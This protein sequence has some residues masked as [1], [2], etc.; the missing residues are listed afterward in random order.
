MGTCRTLKHSKIQL[1]VLFGP[2]YCDILQ[3]IRNFNYHANVSDNIDTESGKRMEDDGTFVTI[4]PNTIKAPNLKYNIFDKMLSNEM[5]SIKHHLFDK[6]STYASSVYIS[7]QDNVPTPTLE[8]KQKWPIEKLLL[9]S[10]IESIN[11]KSTE[12][13]DYD[14]KVVVFPPYSSITTTID[15]QFHSE[16]ENIDYTKHKIIEVRS[17]SNKPVLHTKVPLVLR[18]KQICSCLK[19]N[20]DTTCSKHCTASEGCSRTKKVCTHTDEYKTCQSECTRTA[21]NNIMSITLYPY[22]PSY[23]LGVSTDPP[24]IYYHPNVINELKLPKHKHRH[25]NKPYDYQ[26]EENEKDDKGENYYYEDTSK[27]YYSDPSVTEYKNKKCRKCK[28]KYN[29]NLL[30]TVDFNS[31]NLEVESKDRF[32]EEVVEDLKAYYSDAVIRDCYCSFS[33]FNLKIQYKF[34]MLF[35]GLIHVIM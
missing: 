26:L 31:G 18:Q 32:I 5:L 20:Q 25:S 21:F 30:Q 28:Y 19:T 24:N 33:A 4:I 15:N 2:Y 9:K 3:N 29:Q 1:V 12:E 6:N 14:R 11:V 34:V 27:D 10:K 23:F 8:L 22:Y 7:L 13:T 16:R 17:F 35:T